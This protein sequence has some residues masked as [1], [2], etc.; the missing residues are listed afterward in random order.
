[1]GRKS[2]LQVLNEAREL[3]AKGFTQG[4]Y[5]KGSNGNDVDAMSDDAT[6]FCTLGALARVEGFN[7]RAAYDR[8]AV[9]MYAD[10]EAVREITQTLIDLFGGDAER[11][12]DRVVVVPT[13]NDQATQEQVLQVFDITINRVKEQS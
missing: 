8:G 2:T 10:S 5:A 1:M 9:G 7:T 3:I 4:S 6:C 12:E 11:E 13:Y